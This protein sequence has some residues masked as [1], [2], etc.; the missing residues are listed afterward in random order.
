[1]PLAAGA[2]A[3]EDA[4]ASSEVVAVVEDCRSPSMDDMLVYHAS[5]CLYVGNKDVF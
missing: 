2:V 1:M 3:L 4:E 5:I